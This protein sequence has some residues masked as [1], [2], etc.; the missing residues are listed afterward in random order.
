[1]STS[2]TERPAHH[3]PQVGISEGLFDDK[4]GGNSSPELTQIKQETND[5]GIFQKTTPFSPQRRKF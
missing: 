5:R 2:V 4:K 1:M 3:Q